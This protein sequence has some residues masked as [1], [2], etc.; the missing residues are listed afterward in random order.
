MAKW[1]GKVGYVIT[2]KIGPGKW[3]EI[4]TEKTYY[5]DVLRMSYLNQMQSNSGNADLRINRQISIVA[6]QFAYDNIGRIRYVEFM[7]TNWSVTSADPQRPRII[8]TL[9][10]EYNG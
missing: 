1:Y 2:E 6:D 10:G 9:G 3:D 8:L 4:P 5:G 7:G